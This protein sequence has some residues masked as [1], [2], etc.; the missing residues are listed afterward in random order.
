[1]KGESKNPK[2]AGQR[3][4]R[5]GALP[6]LG[7]VAALLGVSTAFNLG[8]ETE[9]SR[10]SDVS[11]T[12]APVAGTGKIQVSGVGE[13]S[14]SLDDSA[15][16][17]SATSDG[18]LYRDGREIGGVSVRDKE[19]GFVL[20]DPYGATVR[21]KAKD[22]SG[23][24]IRDE[25]GN[26]LYR[27]K[28]KEDKFNVYDGAGK[29]ILYGKEKKGELRLRDDAGTEIGRIEGITDLAL[30]AILAVPISTE[31]RIAALVHRVEQLM[32]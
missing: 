26:V 24:S 30:A 3:P 12:G 7:L 9:T 8:A 1:M 10:S 6:W 13:F 11:A 18:T 23:Y 16:V 15:G 28:L 2:S 27:V 4:A 31:L 19:D 22:D 21:F 14:L 20:T 5:A 29:R 17:R 25:E 32:P